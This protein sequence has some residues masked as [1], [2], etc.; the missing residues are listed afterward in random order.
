[1]LLVGIILNEYNYQWDNVVAAFHAFTKSPSKPC[2]Y[3]K[4][5]YKIIYPLKRQSQ[6]QQTKYFAT[7]FP[8]YDKNKV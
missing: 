5:K 8:I 6:L 2:D 7:S 3:D 4:W 1:M